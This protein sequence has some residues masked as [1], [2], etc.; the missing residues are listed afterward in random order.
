MLI[1]IL[2]T[3]MKHNRGDVDASKF[4]KTTNELTP[5]VKDALGR[6]SI[7]L[8]KEGFK[9]SKIVSIFNNA[10][11]NVPVRTLTHWEKR[12]ED[13]GSGGITTFI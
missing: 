10:G 4:S 5:D 7:A 2:Y 8:K 9:K 11:F 12:I 1:L 13:E 6:V 3:I